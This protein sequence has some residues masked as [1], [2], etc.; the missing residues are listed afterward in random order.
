MPDVFLY[1]GEPNPMD[2]KLRDP[3][4]LDAPPPPAGAPLRALMG[5]G[6]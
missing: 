6:S 5:I 1:T 2:V 4:V 3:T